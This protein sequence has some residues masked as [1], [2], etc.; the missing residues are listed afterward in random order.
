MAA[1]RDMCGPYSAHVNR[2]E[3]RPFDRG[4][5]GHGGLLVALFGQVV[6]DPGRDWFGRLRV[7]PDSGQLSRMGEVTFG[8]HGNPFLPAFLRL[9][10]VCSGCFELTRRGILVK[11]SSIGEGIV[12]G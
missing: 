10:G 8:L 5:A 12:P 4:V 1:T 2:A 3:V 11:Y 6:L 9:C 7:F